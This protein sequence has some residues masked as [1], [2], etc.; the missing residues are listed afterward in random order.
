MKAKVGYLG[1]MLLSGAWVFAQNTSPSS[2]PTT[3]SPTAGQSSLT[4]C[5][6]SSA[7]GKYIL[8]DSTG[9]KYTLMGSM[10]ALSGHVGQQVQVSGQPATPPAAQTSNAGAVNDGSQGV[11]TPAAAE[12]VPNRSFFQ[13]SSATKVADSCSA[14]SSRLMNEGTVMNAA[15]IIPQAAGSGSGAGTAGA[16]QGVGATGQSTGTATPQSTPQSTQ[17]QNP[18]GMPGAATPT[19]GTATPPAGTAT[20]TPAP[21]GAN[22]APGATT[23]NP[24][25]GMQ[26]SE[27]P[28]TTTPSQIPDTT[29]PNTTPNTTTP[30]TPDATPGSTTPGNTM[31]QN[32]GTAPQSTNPG[33]TPP[34]STPSSTPGTTRP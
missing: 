15:L 26:P 17:G 1:I 8:T 30:G 2:S 33:T 24:T 5:L 21:D 25:P 16:S 23:P 34:S 12:P 19:P 14:P 32:P 13:V 10:D 22:S 9:M 7:N 20:P 31:P 11:G 28:N 6:S 18:A 4:G 29:T 27:V 3:S